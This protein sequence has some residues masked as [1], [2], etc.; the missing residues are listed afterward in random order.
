MP[1]FLNLRVDFDTLI[2][3]NLYGLPVHFATA[4]HIYTDLPVNIYLFSLIFPSGKTRTVTCQ[5]SYL[6]TYSQT[7]EHKSTYLDGF[8]SANHEDLPGRIQEINYKNV[9]VEH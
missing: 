5:L 4:L 7:Y 6:P 2:P 8:I 1:L 3:T 9:P